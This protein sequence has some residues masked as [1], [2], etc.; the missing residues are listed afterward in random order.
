MAKVTGVLNEFKAFVL[1]GNILDLAIAVVI[2][3]AFGAVVTAFSEGILMA[4]IAAIFG[5]PNFDAIRIHAG[6]GE[7]LVGSF[8]TAVVNF[9]LIAA[10]LFLVLKAVARAFPPKG[11]PA[12][13]APAPSDEALLLTEIR[14][15]LRRAVRG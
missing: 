6:D 10:V 4:T 9:L 8:F 14:D 12:E 5:E 13:E 1:R 2:G 11:E 15:L 7:I 3:V